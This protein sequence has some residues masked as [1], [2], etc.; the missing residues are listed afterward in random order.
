[1]S[2]DS[3][4]FAYPEAME[5]HFTPDQEAKR[6]EIATAGTDH[7]S[8]VKEE[9]ARFRAAIRE[10][11]VQADRSEFTEENEMAAP[12]ADVAFR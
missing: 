9:D 11:I 4:V 6:A 5:V 12:G 2:T 10:G 3:T 1:M 8:L 7:G